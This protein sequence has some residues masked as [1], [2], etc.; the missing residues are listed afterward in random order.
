METRSH[1]SEQEPLM[2]PSAEQIRTEIKE[3]TGKECVETRILEDEKGVYLM[4]FE[5]DGENPGETIQYEY[6]RKG[7]YQQG[8]I[9]ETE[10]H[11]VYCQDKMPVSGT[12]AARLVD[13]EWVT[14]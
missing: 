3:L 8:A 2:I 9:T 1:F 11:V 13:G 4:E 12:S 14:L 7:K 5:V 10:M 6:M